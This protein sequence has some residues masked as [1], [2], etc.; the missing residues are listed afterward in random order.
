MSNSFIPG[1]IVIIHG[2]KSKIQWNWKRGRILQYD[3]KSNR[4]AVKIIQFKQTAL[5]KVHNLTFVSKQRYVN[6]LQGK[7]SCTSLQYETEFIW[8]IPNKQMKIYITLNKN[9]SFFSPIFEYKG[10]SLMIEFFPNGCCMESDNEGNVSLG[11]ICISMPYNT[12]ITKFEYSIVIDPITDSLR[13]QCQTFNKLNKRSSIWQVMTT[14]H[15]LKTLK[16]IKVITTFKDISHKIN[17]NRNRIINSNDLIHFSWNILKEQPTYQS[18]LN[19]DFFTGNSSEITHHNAWKWRIQFFKTDNA[20]AL[21]LDLVEYPK[22]MKSV[23]T[24][25]I[26]KCN[27]LNIGCINPH[28]FSINDKRLQIGGEICS[29]AYYNQNI[30]SKIMTFECILD[31]IECI[32]MNGNSVSIDPILRDKQLKFKKTK[33]N[34]DELIIA[35]WLRNLGLDVLEIELM[36]III[37]HLNVSQ[38]II[39]RIMNFENDKDLK[40]ILNAYPNAKC[41]NVRF[42]EYDDLMPL[43]L[44]DGRNPFIK[45]VE[46]FYLA[47]LEETNM[48][49]NMFNTFE[50]VPKRASLIIWQLKSKESDVKLMPEQSEP[51]MTTFRPIP[52]MHFIQYKLT[53]NTQWKKLNVSLSY[54][55]PSNA[56]PDLEMMFNMMESMNVYSGRMKPKTDNELKRPMMFRAWNAE[57][58]MYEEFDVVVAVESVKYWTIVESMLQRLYKKIVPNRMSMKM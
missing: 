51:D 12:E 13:K 57:D 1:D 50:N 54:F 24:H 47:I 36:K 46:Q 45:I 3:S 42:L 19:E 27:Q 15:K 8:K 25:A 49:M 16:N 38:K 21:A 4:Y 44:I 30:D 17:K 9:Y 55:H 32:D 10:I 29:I 26:L 6:T 22:Y 23:D 52:V 35:N 20:I 28:T 58:M 18:V 40:I 31:I 14:T 33:L 34:I 43:G 11:L 56:K 2:I 48:E 41:V 39:D 5:L 53:K 7:I 37:K